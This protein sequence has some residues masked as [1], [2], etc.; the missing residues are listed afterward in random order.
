MQIIGNIP[1][2]SKH[3]LSIIVDVFYEITQQKKPILIFSHGF[4]GF[5]DWG[6][7]N[8]IAPMF[9]EAG[10][11]FVKFN[12]SHNG[13]TIKY[14]TEFV[15]LDNFGNNNFSKELDDLGC[16]IDWI[17]N[18]EFVSNKEIDTNNIFL[19][20]HSRGGSICILKAIEDK[21]IKKIVT[22]SAVNDFAA[23]WSDAVLQEWKKKGVKMIE[24]T[25]TKQLMP[26]YYQV[27]EDYQKNRQRLHIPDAVKKLKIPF[28]AVHGTKDE[29]VP[30]K[31]AEEMKQWN[32]KLELL[33]IEDA[34]HTF[35]VVHPPESNHLP[36]HSQKVINATIKFLNEA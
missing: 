21:R 12:F 16:V 15:N 36:E 9:A 35:G 22:W 29:S 24:N 20:G 34:N 14:P 19:L 6:H 18:N 1:I 8:L 17:G 30:F 7:Y 2:T 28:L 5:K 4:K 23:G 31:Q 13:T 33:A 32:K 11:V 10:F 25:R 3:N 27:V 26:L